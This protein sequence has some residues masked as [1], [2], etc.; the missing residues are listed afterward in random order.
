M[1]NVPQEPWAEPSE[2]RQS[3]PSY[4][5]HV[6]GFVGKPIGFETSFQMSCQYPLY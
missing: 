3:R 1:M 4:G 6:N 5:S 2:S